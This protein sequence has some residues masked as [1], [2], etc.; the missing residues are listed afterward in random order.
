MRILVLWSACFLVAAAQQPPAT[1]KAGVIGAMFATTA[2]ARMA[3]PVTFQQ[4]LQI[5]ERYIT[6]HKVPIERYW[7]REITWV[8]SKEMKLGRPWENSYWHLWWSRAVSDNVFIDV[9]MSARPVRRP[10]E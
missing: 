1:P 5:A 10:S 6:V 4:A 8:P 3:P 2:V 9:D 7:L